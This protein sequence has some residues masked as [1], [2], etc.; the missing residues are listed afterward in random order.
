[1]N[2]PN[3]LLSIS[4][5]V[6]IILTIVAKGSKEVDKKPIIFVFELIRHGSRTGTNKLG[7]IWSK[8]G[9]KEL[10]GSGMREQYLMGEN[11]K[12]KYIIENNFLDIKY[13]KEQFY[14]RSTNTNRTIMSAQSQI[15]GIY[16]SSRSTL[17]PTQETL[18]VPPIKLS[19]NPKSIHST[20]SPLPY[21]INIPPIHKFTKDK[22]PFKN[23]VCKNAVKEL[24]K[25]FKESHHAHNIY[26]YN[27]PFIR[28]LMKTLRVENYTLSITTSIL[29]SINCLQSNG[30]LD[31]LTDLGVS[32]HVALNAILI[33][34][35]LARYKYTTQ[36]K[37][38]YHPLRR[39]V[40][41]VYTEILNVL[42]RGV[43][44]YKN[45]SK[46]EDL[47]FKF[48]LAVSHDTIISPTIKMLGYNMSDALPF[49]TSLLLELVLEDEHKMK[50]LTKSNTDS[51]I[52]LNVYIN[53]KLWKVV[54]CPGNCNYPQFVKFIHEKVLIPVDQLNC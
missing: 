10:T 20:S 54:G 46:S 50:N 5:I 48:E 4:F 27:M 51:T 19:F 6:I 43:N 25:G 37:G 17:S 38:S 23:S 29:S 42:E 26:I 52:G 8:E 36:P 41:P 34:N 11:I 49:A 47:K 44:D 53:G 21:E 39:L 13:K 32:V 14:V 2:S 24:A 40:T 33:W 3:I 45:S 15:L 18:A 31:K 12:Q 16:K 1:M 30:Q 9:E 22:D 35:Q 28:Q 7:G